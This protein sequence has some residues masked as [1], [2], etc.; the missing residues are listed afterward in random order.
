MDSLY[1]PFLHTWS[2]SIEAQFYIIFP[3]ILFLIFKFLKKFLVYILIFLFFSSLIFAHYGSINFS[4]LNFYTLPS[5][6]WELLAGSILAVY[7]IKIGHRG[8]NKKLTKILP[9]IGIL[10][11][12]HSILFFNDGMLHPSYFTLSPVIGS[13]LLIWFSNKDE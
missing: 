2:L 11:I 7:E 13:C 10:L 5:R 6:V 1:K 3:L 12:T 8:E 4:S 9:F